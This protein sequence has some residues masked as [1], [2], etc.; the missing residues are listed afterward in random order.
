MAV[1]PATPEYIRWS[2]VSITFNRGNHPNFIPK[3]GRYPLVV[4]PIIKDVKLNRVLVDGGCSLNLF[5]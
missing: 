2:E 5:F 1:G 4:Y 3:S